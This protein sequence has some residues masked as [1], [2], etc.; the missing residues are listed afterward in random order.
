M[1]DSAELARVVRGGVNF[2]REGSA[3]ATGGTRSRASAFGRAALVAA[4]L[5]CAAAGTPPAFADGI[6]WETPKNITG[7]ADVRTD[8]VPCYAYARSAVVVNG[9]SFTNKF[10]KT[11]I[12][13]GVETLADIVHTNLTTVSAATT[14]FGTGNPA[15]ATDAHKYLIA[16][17]IYLNGDTP[18]DI[19]LRNLLPGHAYLVQ[20]WVNDPRNAT[21]R[22]RYLILDGCLTLRYGGTASGFGQHV[23]GHFTATSEEQTFTIAGRCEEGATPSTQYNAIQVRD[24]TPGTIEWEEPKDITSD[25]DVRTDGETVFACNLAAS[26]ATVNGVTFV[27]E[28]DVSAWYDVNVT[29]ENYQYHN[30][31]A[32]DDEEAEET[33]SAEYKRVIRG[34]IHNNGRAAPGKIHLKGLAP[35]GRYLVQIWTHDYRSNIGP[36]RYIKIDC[37]PRLVLR[38]STGNGQHVTGVF[39]AD[40]PTRTITVKRLYK[41]VSSGVPQVNAIQLRRLDSGAATHWRIGHITKSDNDVRLDGE[42]LYAYNFDNGTTTAEVNGVT[43]AGWKRP[44]VTGENDDF[45]WAFSAGTG[46]HASTFG[47]T[48]SGVSSG[49]LTM[50]KSATYTSGGSNDATPSTLTL[51]RLTPGHRYL[52][53]LWV[54][55]GRANSTYTFIRYRY[56][57]LDGAATMLYQNQGVFSPARGDFATGIFTATATTQTITMQSGHFQNDSSRAVQLNGMQVRD[58]GPAT[59]SAYNVWAG[60]ANGAW[61]D[62]AA[63]WN[64]LAGEPREGTLWDAANGATNTAL[65]GSAATALPS[66]DLTVGGIAASGALTVG[67]ANDGRSVSAGFVEAGTCAFK[68]AWASDVLAKYDLGSFTLDGASPNLA[69]VIAGGGSLTLSRT[70]ALLDGADLNVASNATLTLASG[71][72][73]VLR[74]LAGEGTLAFSGTVTLTNE[75]TQTFTGTLDGDVVVRKAGYGDWTLGGTHTGSLA[76]DALEGTTILGTDGATVTVAEGAKVSLGGGTRSLGTVSG[77]GAITNGTLSTALSIAD[78]SDITLEEITLSTGVTLNGASSVTFAGDKDLSGL[79]IHIADPAAAKAANKA[80]VAVEGELTGEPAFTFGAGGYRAKLAADGKG[81]VVGRMGFMVIVR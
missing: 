81:Y 75:S 17:G 49:Y 33:I 66:G 55:D 53:Q 68:S 78:S 35:G 20:F 77:E 19:T 64:D 1:H 3:S 73:P 69:T 7:D 65:F 4:A 47:I 24:V 26:G 72:A 43:F 34:G 11:H 12:P 25:G 13:D 67:A 30:T 74:R 14:T 21:T 5:F 52:V 79:S 57:V 76:L 31:T 54:H 39:T 42:L 80:V 58:L 37:G 70:D 10:H 32:F 63:N 29:F 16:G 15:G 62:D 8:G 46:N 61:G 28:A 59:D 45:A 23:T 60:G 44:S 71:T 56:M 48:D 22:K 41:T 36:Y 18:A 6:R 38:T 27:P 51:K 50:I 9:V 40:A 2:P